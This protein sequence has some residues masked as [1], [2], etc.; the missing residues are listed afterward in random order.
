MNNW[1]N[2]RWQNEIVVA[3]P[4]IERYKPFEITIVNQ[5]GNLKICVDGKKRDNFP[6][7]AP[8]PSDGYN[9]VLVFSKRINIILVY[10]SSTQTCLCST[11]K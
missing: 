3:L 6:H 2:D 1:L 4:H 10:F 8:N 7:R 5:P 9:T 11:T